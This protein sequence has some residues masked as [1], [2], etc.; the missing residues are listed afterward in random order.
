[1]SNFEYDEILSLILKL[2]EKY[3]ISD[4]K[5]F[6]DALKEKLP[7]EFCV[8]KYYTDDFF[9]AY[10]TKYGLGFKQQPAGS[11]SNGGNGH[12]LNGSNSIHKS[13]GFNSSLSDS[14]EMNKSSPKI[15]R[16]ADG[17]VPSYEKKEVDPK[18]I[19]TRKIRSELNKLSDENYDKIASNIEPMIIEGSTTALSEFIVLIF[20]K[21]HADVTF[22]FLL[23]HTKMCLQ[24]DRKFE[25]LREILLSQCYTEF[26]KQKPAKPE[27]NIES[28]EYQEELIEYAEEEHKWKTNRKTSIKFISELKKCEMVDDK[29][30]DYVLTALLITNHSLNDPNSDD[31]SHACELLELSSI[32]EEILQ[33]F[34][35]RIDAFKNA[36]KLAI[37][38]QVRIQ[39]IVEKNERYLSERLKPAPYRPP[40]TNKNT[41]TSKPAIKTSIEVKNGNSRYPRGGGKK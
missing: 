34:M 22:K 13:N 21:V 19:W 35:K 33:K 18:I 39:K 11:T 25:K 24:F 29:I 5:G 8:G 32:G 4:L 16:S 41:P 28:E 3:G 38:D 14:K 1:M 23:L 31:I 9:Q 36:G 20:D 2:S 10:R 30:V 7:A 17:F 15:E 26:N 6:E 12:K 27:G 40:R 37:I